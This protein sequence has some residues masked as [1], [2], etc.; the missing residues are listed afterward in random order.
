MK[1]HALPTTTVSETRF[2][3][4]T[5]SASHAE[6]QSIMVRAMRAATQAQRKVIEAYEQKEK[7]KRANQV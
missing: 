3:H 7:T 6:R 4:F 2:A 5:R 1:Q